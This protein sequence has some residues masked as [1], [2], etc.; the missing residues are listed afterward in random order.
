M[1]IVRA[2]HSLVANQRPESVHVTSDTGQRFGHSQRSGPK[3][4]PGQ[5]G[6][7]LAFVMEK[8]DKAGERAIRLTRACMWKRALC[9]QTGVKLEP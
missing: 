9:G 1:S 3:P 8:L 4:V 7:A 2:V 5:T 6:L